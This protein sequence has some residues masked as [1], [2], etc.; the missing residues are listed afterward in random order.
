MEIL[1]RGNWIS[2]WKWVFEWEKVQTSWQVFFFGALTLLRFFKSKC[3]E[4]TSRSTFFLFVSKQQ[5]AVSKVVAPTFFP[6]PLHVPIVLSSLSTVQNLWRRFVFYWL[7]FKRRSFCL[8]F[9]LQ[10]HTLAWLHAFRQMGW[11]GMVAHFPMYLLLLLTTRNRTA[12][13]ELELQLNWK[14]AFENCCQQNVYI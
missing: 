12:Q 3:F 13:L 8:I 6:H 5:L 7:C 14:Y 11:D 1:L 9:N 2:H 10:R 4:I